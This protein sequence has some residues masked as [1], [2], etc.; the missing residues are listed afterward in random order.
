MLGS[1]LAVSEAR[2][3]DLSAQQSVQS[4]E[5]LPRVKLDG[6]YF[7]ANGRPFVVTGA[8][9]VPAKAAMAWSTQWDPKDIDADFAKMRELGF[10]TVRVDLMWAWF[11]PRPGNYNEEAFRQLDYIISLAHKYK[12]YLHPCL[13]IGGEVGEAYWDVPWRHGRNPQSDP[14]M[15]RL[16]TDHASELARRY[17][18]ESAI[19]AWD[20]TDEP[21]FWIVAAGTTDAEAINWTRLIV[22]AIRKYDKNHPIV[23][24]VSTEDVGHGPFRPDNIA[25]EVDFFSVHPYSIY[26][27][28]LFPDPMI[29]ERGTYGAAYQTTLSGS[30]G[31]SVMVQEMGASSAQ[32]SPERIAA[33]E[34]VNVYSGLATGT[35]GFLLWCFT[36]AAPHQISKYPYLRS[37]H[38]TQ[39]GI[40]T[41]DR[42]DRPQAI[43]FKKFEQVLARMDL[44][45]IVPAPADAA[46]VVPD[47]WSKPQ[48][49]FSRSGLTGPE[50]IPYVSLYD[51]MAMPGTPKPNVSESNKWL[52]GA[53]LSSFVL[54]RRA[55][56][57]ADMPRE[58]GDWAK[59]PMVL[60]PSPLTGTDD[61]FVHVHSDF[62]QKT[63]EY[64][65][66]GGV[67]YASVAA[68]A[69][70]PEMQELFGARL[71]DSVPVSDVTLKIVEPFG[72]L[73]P[74]E[75][76]H[77]AVPGSGLRY[78]GALLEVHG[79]T[80]IAVDQDGRPALIAH[81]FGAGKVLLSAY[82]LENYIA[83]TM[84]AYER[85]DNT[86]RI[87]A[88]FRAWAGLKSRFRTDQPSVELG[89][90]DGKDRGY[91]VLV[92]HS[93]QPQDVT[94]TATIPVHSVTVIAPDGT[95][96]VSLN[97]LFWKVRVQP[98]DGA[99]VEW[100]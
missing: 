17:A 27:P 22:G 15:L 11:E 82:P 73:K 23:A 65:S 5:R 92:N 77:Y 6:N 25:S 26:M 10:N 62:W 38:E 41:W 61:Y 100:K 97:G 7:S 39:F 20:L 79:G 12:I 21:P 14:V 63:K 72:D 70:I 86:H 28:D 31:H 13:F 42:K 34:R 76:F 56:F 58:Y 3:T 84:S 80:V 24:G 46:I 9:W 50:V 18:N 57:K 30:A 68:D 91:V 93:G 40:T 49:D 8:H 16:E 19:L 55:G 33:Y 4:T 89:A 95:H 48:G 69:A 81:S 66:R 83:G 88:A 78:W 37:P 67:L 44:A 51:Q 75:T 85:G 52:Q 1:Q 36:D 29:S 32:Y 47:E 53:W 35:N 59:R 60:L 2:S 71:A 98:Y 87:Y 45:G 96:P 64:V 43:E 90:L 54:S 94:V 74:G 99:V